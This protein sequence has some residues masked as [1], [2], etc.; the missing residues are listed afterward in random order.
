MTKQNYK[1]LQLYFKG[2]APDFAGEGGLGYG[3]GGGGG[4]FQQDG[5]RYAGGNGE[6]GLVVVE[7]DS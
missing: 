5:I 2:H 6:D 1:N 4:G 7:W 3:G